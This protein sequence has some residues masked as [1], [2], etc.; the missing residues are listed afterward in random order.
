MHTI[1]QNKRMWKEFSIGFHPIWCVEFDAHVAQYE[2]SKHSK[3]ICNPPNNHW[4]Y[5][6]AT[7]NTRRICKAKLVA[8]TT[9]GC[10]LTQS[11]NVTKSHPLRNSDPYGQMC[12]NGYGC[13][14]IKIE[15][16]WPLG[17]GEIE[18]NFFW[19]NYCLLL[20][21]VHALNLVHPSSEPWVQ[22]HKKTA[23]G[24]SWTRL[25]SSNNNYLKAVMCSVGCMTPVPRGQR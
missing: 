14:H 6:M 13:K 23:T 9:E 12:T 15:A 5:T 19:A 22:L 1:E 3:N 11:H 4:T 10:A 25:R 8:C 24:W 20:A 2:S 16:L 7:I 17:V 21:T 18:L